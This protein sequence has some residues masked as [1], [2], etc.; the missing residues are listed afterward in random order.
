MFNGVKSMFSGLGFNPYGEEI[1][2]TSTLDPNIHLTPEKFA[3]RA[4]AEVEPYRYRIDP[5][6]LME[7]FPR[8]EDQVHVRE[9]DQVFQEDALKFALTAIGGIL[10]T[11][12]KKTVRLGFGHYTYK[13]QPV[14]GKTYRFTRTPD[15]ET[16]IAA[17][18]PPPFVFGTI[19]E[20]KEFMI[21]KTSTAAYSMHIEKKPGVYSAPRTSYGAAY[22][23]PEYQKRYVQTSYGYTSPIPKPTSKISEPL[24]KRSIAERTYVFSRHL[25]KL[26]LKSPSTW[27]AI[28]KA[29]SDLTLAHT[30]STS[31]STETLNKI[32]EAFGDI[33]NELSETYADFVSTK[34]LHP[35]T[36]TKGFSRPKPQSGKFA[37]YYKH[38][39]GAPPPR[40]TF[41]QPS[42]PPDT[43]PF[44]N[45]Y[46]D[47]ENSSEFN[48]FADE[49][50]HAHVKK[51]LI[52][53]STLVYS[54]V[55]DELGLH[56]PSP[57]GTIKS[58]MKQLRLKYH[59]DKTTK[60]TG[61][62]QVINDLFDRIKS[63]LKPD[64]DGL[65]GRM[66]KQSQSKSKA[67]RKSRKSRRS[68][69]SK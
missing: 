25:K 33:K 54:H 29:V 7:N 61:K 3:S 42:N 51:D 11:L 53:S 38:Y 16:N 57:W 49:P 43:T 35:P 52:Q 19:P 30:G 8:P 36:I 65:G 4:F 6:F 59:P 68:R 10:K 12:G 15:L 14:W 34:T 20:P 56:N 69:R 5:G 37:E 31:E 58:R 66:R 32:H 22:V 26:G 28:K 13:F 47:T 27:G 40:A 60:D 46:M 64:Y 44:S 48:P 18:A 45:P 9:L 50:V 21:P 63:D 24:K 23:L 62:I 41:P 1:I 55:L 39:T 17:A 2:A 67:S